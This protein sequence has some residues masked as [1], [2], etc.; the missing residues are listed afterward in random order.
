MEM[1]SKQPQTTDFIQCSLC[2]V[3]QKNKNLLFGRNGFCSV[4]HAL[5]AT[6]TLAPLSPY[7][8]PLSKNLVIQEKPVPVHIHVTSRSS[9]MTSYRGVLK[10]LNTVVRCQL[11]KGRWMCSESKFYHKTQT[12]DKNLVENGVGVGHFLEVCLF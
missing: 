4:N 8:P 6:I 11:D 2:F 12:Y 1:K 10:T 7:R 5:R 3:S 9:S